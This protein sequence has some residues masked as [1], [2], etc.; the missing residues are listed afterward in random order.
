M[1]R[2]PQMRGGPQRSSGRVVSC[3]ADCSTQQCI[4]PLTQRAAVLSSDQ[5]DSPLVSKKT[6]EERHDGNNSVN[7]A[8]DA[9]HFSIGPGVFWRRELGS[10]FSTGERIVIVSI[11][12]AMVKETGR[13]EH[14]KCEGS[15]QQRDSQPG[16][17]C[18]LNV[19][20]G[21]MCQLTLLDQEK[22]L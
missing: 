4:N 7:S 13:V 20:R 12:I 19:I 22:R 9:N 10:W 14:G 6:P 15:D 16:D 2:D 11:A 3:S 18:S 17:P 21:R 1:K 8:K 5:H